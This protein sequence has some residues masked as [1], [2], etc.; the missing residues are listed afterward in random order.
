MS[1]VVSSCLSPYVSPY[2]SVIVLLTL[3]LSFYRSAAFLC[4]LF[5]S[6]SLFLSLSVLLFI[7]GDA[8][9]PMNE[10]TC[11]RMSLCLSLSRLLF[12]SVSL[13]L[14]FSRSLSSSLYFLFVLSVGLSFTLSLF[15]PYC[16]SRSLVFSPTKI[17]TRWRLNSVRWYGNY[18]IP[19][20]P[21]PL[22]WPGLD[23]QA[24][25]TSDPAPRAICCLPR[26][27]ELITFGAFNVG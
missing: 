4:F 15:L 12:L 20:A 24:F 19:F 16:L 2:L 1:V 7:C 10:D 17:L 11:M 27:S 3:C 6:L 26:G 5:S 22:P 9:Y 14:A 25:V 23:V 21:L 8:F 13:A 18:A